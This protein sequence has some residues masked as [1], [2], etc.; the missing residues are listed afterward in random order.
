MST[1]GSVTAVERQK[2]NDPNNSGP[3]ARL[4]EQTLIMQVGLCPDPPRANFLP[5]IR[6]RRFHASIAAP[7]AEE[8]ASVSQIYITPD[9]RYPT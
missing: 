9:A 3:H 6:R 8:I 5:A 4:H 7:G 2:E 1:W